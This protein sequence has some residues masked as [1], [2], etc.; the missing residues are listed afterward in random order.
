M[1]IEMS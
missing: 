1:Q